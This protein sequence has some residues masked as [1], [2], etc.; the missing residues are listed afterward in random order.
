MKYRLHL[1]YS[2][3]DATLAG[4]FKRK[5]TFCNVSAGGAKNQI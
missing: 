5:K 3:C 2:T 1:L 4:D